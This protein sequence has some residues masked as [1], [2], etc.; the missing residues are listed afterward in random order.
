M[1]IVTQNILKL[2]KM[3]V[4]YQHSPVFLYYINININEKFSL[5]KGNLISGYTV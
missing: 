1:L 2:R 3:I 5:Q 4:I